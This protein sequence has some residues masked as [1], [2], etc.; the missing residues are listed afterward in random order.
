MY[1]NMKLRGNRSWDNWGS[2]GFIFGIILIIIGIINS[3][4]RISTNL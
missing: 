4:S 2:N 3:S 1:P